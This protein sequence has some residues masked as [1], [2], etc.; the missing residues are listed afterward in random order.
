MLIYFQNS[1]VISRTE[2]T[3]STLPCTCSVSRK[4]IHSAQKIIFDMRPDNDVF[5]FKIWISGI[6]ISGPTSGSEPFVAGFFVVNVV[7]RCF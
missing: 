3:S 6:K 4:R 7:D 1:V 5:V 2:C